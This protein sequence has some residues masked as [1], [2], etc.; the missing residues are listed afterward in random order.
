MTNFAHG[1]A[2][3]NAAANYLVQ[4]GFKVIDQNWRRRMC[5]IDI[6]ARKDDVIYFVEVKYREHGYQGTG[7]EYIT[8][9]KLKQMTFAASMW[10]S[11]NNWNEDYN[12]SAIE[13]AGSDYAV[14][15][16]IDS[17]L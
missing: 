17:V 11:E 8:P 14:T 6:V 13:V 10:V 7:L 9:T 15:E 12:L 1:R 2:A 16:F 3:E 5:E 4:Q